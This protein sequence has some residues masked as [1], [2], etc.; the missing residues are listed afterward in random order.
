MVQKKQDPKTFYF[1]ILTANPFLCVGKNRF[2]IYLFFEEPFL[3]EQ[4]LVTNMGQNG[5]TSRQKNI[6]RQFDQ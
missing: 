4:L 5:A 3:E 1:V 2:E 6:P